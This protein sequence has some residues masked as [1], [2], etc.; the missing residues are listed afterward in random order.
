MR[1]TNSAK[2]AYALASEYGTEQSRIGSE[3]KAGGA[4]PRAAA[5]A[6]AASA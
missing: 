4:A 1:A 5:A 3:M 6:R 2:S